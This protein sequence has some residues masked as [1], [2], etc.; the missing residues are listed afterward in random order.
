VTISGPFLAGYLV[1]HHGWRGVFWFLFALQLAGGLLV[2]AIVPES[3]VRNRIRIDWLGATL[4]GAGVG[5]VLL[6]LS[7]G[8]TWHWGD[9]RTLACLVGGAALMAAWVL[10][11]S[12]LE[13]PLMDLRLLRSRPITTIMVTSMFGGAALAGAATLLPMMVQTPHGLG[14]D[15]GFGLTATQVVRFTVPAG[16]LTVLCGFALGAA[17]RRVGPR[18]PLIAGGALSVIGGLG[19]AF[20]HSTQLG[21]LL[22]FALFGIAQAL[23]FSSLP[24]L[25]IASVPVESQAISAGMT[26]TMQALGTAAGTQVLFVILTGHVAKLIQGTPIYADSGYVAAFVLAAAFAVVAVIAALAVP[27]RRAAA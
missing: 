10:A 1:D 15:Y 5:L 9:P 27:L 14:G 25:V 24:N 3:P 13:E 8:S 26:N 18:V 4:I 22:S 6:G 17:M 11:E 19:L 2:L 20:A 23:I 12:R 21:V 16:A 7:M